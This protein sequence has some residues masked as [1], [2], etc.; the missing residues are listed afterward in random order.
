MTKFRVRPQIIYEPNYARYARP[1]LRYINPT[2]A[3]QPLYQY[4]QLPYGTQTYATQPIYAPASSYY[5]YLP[6]AKA[7][8]A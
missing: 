2:Y 4:E 3:Q 1:H 6:Y 7:K 8:K 5:Q